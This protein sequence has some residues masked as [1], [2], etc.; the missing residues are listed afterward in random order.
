MRLRPADGTAVLHADSQ[1]PGATPLARSLCTACC[2]RCALPRR[3]GPAWS[4]PRRRWP[5]R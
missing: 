1:A 4:A 5:G 3:A 2:G